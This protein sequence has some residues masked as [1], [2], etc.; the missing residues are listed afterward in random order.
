[1]HSDRVFAPFQNRGRIMDSPQLT[2][3]KTKKKEQLMSN[4]MLSF[5]TDSTLI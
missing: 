4:I 1:M 2:E 3:N 5:C